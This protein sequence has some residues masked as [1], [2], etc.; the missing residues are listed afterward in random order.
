[1]K[2]FFL[3]FVKYFSLNATP[4]RMKSKLAESYFVC[5]AGLIT[6]SEKIIKK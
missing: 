4:K 1:M 2:K 5:F 6:Q 3:V